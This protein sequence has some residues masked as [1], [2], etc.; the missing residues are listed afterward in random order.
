MG[1]LLQ[2]IF[3]EVVG[4]DPYNQRIA[5]TPMRATKLGIGLDFL[6]GPK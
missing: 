1:E 6:N 4:D 3:R 2:S 5:T